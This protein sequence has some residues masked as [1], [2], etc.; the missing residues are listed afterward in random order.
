[1]YLES[2]REWQALQSG[3]AVPVMSKLL[4]TLFAAFFL[5]DEGLCP[6]Q[7]AVP[8]LQRRAQVDGWDQEREEGE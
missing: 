7:L 3:S 1:M 6:G 5:S 8:R 2:V 4:G